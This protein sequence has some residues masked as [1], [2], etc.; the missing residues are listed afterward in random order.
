MMIFTAEAALIAHY[1]FSDGD[2]LDNEV[3]PG[4]GLI[5]AGPAPV[6]SGDGAAV[7]ASE[8]NLNAT[9][10]NYLLSD[11][12]ADLNLT[13]FTVSFWFK[14]ATV[15]QDGPFCGIFSSRSAADGASW[16]FFSA[17]SGA[18]ATTGATLIRG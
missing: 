15:D 3:G 10:D 12:G 8:P 5:N 4:P 17:G 18:I 13:T 7:F 14:T 11:N 16:Q 1:D 2:L 6:M 9:G